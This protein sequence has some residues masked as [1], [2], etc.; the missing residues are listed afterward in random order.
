MDTVENLGTFVEIEVVIKTQEQNE[1]A[2]SLLNELLNLMNISNGQV[3]DVGY[4]E[5]LMMYNKKSLAYYRDQ[6]K[7]FWVI[8][9]TINEK[10][11]RNQVQPCLFVEKKEGKVSN[12][13]IRL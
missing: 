1:K 4:R 10:L 11:L 2:Q 13:A 7:V 6:N 8:N 5:L 12:F 3:V 9:E